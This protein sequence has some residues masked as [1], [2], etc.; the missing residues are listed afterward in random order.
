[1]KHI[2][3]YVLLS[4]ALG[5]LACG[6]LPED[7][8]ATEGAFTTTE[9]SAIINRQRPG[10]IWDVSVSSSGSLVVDTT[11]PPPTAATV[12]HCKGNGISFVNCTANFINGAGG[13][14]AKV[15]KHT[16]NTYCTTDC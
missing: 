5:L 4:V 15:V 16:N 13:G 10:D 2:L 12:W 9:L 7:E 3:T 14:C 11:V 1:M 6:G 8:G